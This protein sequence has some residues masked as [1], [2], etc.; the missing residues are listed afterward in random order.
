MGSVFLSFS[1]KIIYLRAR[2]F[3]IEILVL[4]GIVYRIMNNELLIII[5]VRNKLQSLKAIIKIH[6][7][8]NSPNYYNL[9]CN[10]HI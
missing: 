10:K 4:S 2:G 9:Y 1:N 8:S 7:K 5:V 3:S 6:Q